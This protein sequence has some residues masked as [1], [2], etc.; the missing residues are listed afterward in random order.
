MF[1]LTNSAQ[2]CFVTLYCDKTSF[3]FTSDMDLS[4]T[5]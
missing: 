1:S 3:M 2:F 4:Y 5:E